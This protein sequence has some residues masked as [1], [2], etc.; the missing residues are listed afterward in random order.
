MFQCGVR[1]LCVITEELPPASG[2]NSVPHKDRAETK[3]HYF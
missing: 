1:Y 3:F 2:T